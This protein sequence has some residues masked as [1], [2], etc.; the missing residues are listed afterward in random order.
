MTPHE[1][2]GVDV[3]DAHVGL[4]RASSLAKIAKPLDT[5]PAKLAIGKIKEI[6]A[7]SG[8]IEVVI[9]LP[10]NLSGEETEQ[11]KKVRR[12]AAELKKQLKAKFY[13]QDEALTSR[14]A[15]KLQAAKNKHR[16]SDEHAEAAAIILQDFLD[17]DELK[18][19]VC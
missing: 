12:W 19:V 14:D 5:V 7:A 2:I 11:T 13:W 4:A 15:A 1:I 8:A 6:A 9:G 3:G 17:T 16:K 10:R 18:R